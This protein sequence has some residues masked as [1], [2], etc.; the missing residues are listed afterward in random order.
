MTNTTTLREQFEQQFC[1]KATDDGVTHYP[2][3][4]TNI[5]QTEAIWYFF[6][7]ELQEAERR[8]REEMITYISKHEWWEETE[9]NY[10]ERF[11]FNP[12]YK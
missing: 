9:D 4:R 11:W 10:R 2:A 12:K 6:Q 1:Y 8:W 7:N 5:D 3:L